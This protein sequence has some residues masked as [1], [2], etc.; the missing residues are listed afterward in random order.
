V[1]D[2]KFWE[3]PAARLYNISAI[4]ASYL[5]D[6]DGKIIAKNLRGNELETKLKDILK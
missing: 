2:L 4:P 6:R 3:S 5:L 1:S